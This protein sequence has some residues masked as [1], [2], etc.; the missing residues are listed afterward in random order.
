MP[1]ARSRKTAVRAPGQL[2]KLPFTARDSNP[3]ALLTLLIDSRLD[4]SGNAAFHGGHWANPDIKL[5]QP[6]RFSAQLHQLTWDVLTCHRR[7]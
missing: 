5:V 7:C 4:D 3:I 6:L 1:P 2:P